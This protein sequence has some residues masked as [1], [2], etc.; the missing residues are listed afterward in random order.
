LPSE[1]LALMLDRP[2]RI[3]HAILD[4]LAAALDTDQRLDKQLSSREVL[5]PTTAHLRMTTEFLAGSPPPSLRP[6]VAA[7]ASL[8]AGLVGYMHYRL[9]HASE[10]VAH[11]QL[12]VELAEEAGDHDLQANILGLW[13]RVLAAGGDNER[14]LG[15]LDRAR[16]AGAQARSARCGRTWRSPEPTPWPE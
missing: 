3:D 5:V 4:E 16:T 14:T 8:A 2:S 6:R 7:L 15:L 10:A 11:Y 1:R 12:A 13:S 9:G